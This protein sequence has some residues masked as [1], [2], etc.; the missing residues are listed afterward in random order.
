M[1]D[2]W[3]KKMVER[4]DKIDEK[5]NDN[6]K[7]EILYQKATTP[8]HY[9]KEEGGKADGQ[10]KRANNMDEK[11][12]EPKLTDPQKE[13]LKD[14]IGNDSKGMSLFKEECDARRIE[15][16]GKAENAIDKL[17]KSQASN[18]IEVFEEMRN[19]DR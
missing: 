2:E 16:K 7:R 8:L 14:L 5:V 18:M 10:I 15:I 3:I 9:F 1:I 13:F 12:D 17:T 6:M 11:F 4:Y 19:N